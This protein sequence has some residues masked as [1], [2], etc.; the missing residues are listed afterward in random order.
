MIQYILF[1]CIYAASRN[2]LELLTRQPGGG[3]GI[4]VLMV[5]AC[6]DGGCM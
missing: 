4:Y 5:G 3:G 1:S 2:N 6:G